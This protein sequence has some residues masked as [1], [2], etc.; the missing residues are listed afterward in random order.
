[1]ANVN[2]L[3]RSLEIVQREV[4]SH[5]WFLSRATEKGHCSRNIGEQQKGNGRGQGGKLGGI[6]VTQ[7]EVTGTGEPPG[8]TEPAGLEVRQRRVRAHR[9]GSAE[10][11]WRWK[12]P[13]YSSQP[14]GRVYVPCPWVWAGVV[15]A[16]QAEVTPCPFV[17]S[18]LTC[19]QLLLPVS[20]DTHSWNPAAIP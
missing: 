1:M 16:F 19:L 14:E 17:D 20:W 5:S 9:A 12:S 6:A 3:P 18:E 10:T 8:E 7:G 15:I 11:G 13:C 2:V 4:G